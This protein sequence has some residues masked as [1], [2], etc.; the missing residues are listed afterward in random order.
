[1]TD[2]PLTFNRG[3]QCGPE[4]GHAHRCVGPSTH[5]AF[6]EVLVP[7]RRAVSVPGPPRFTGDSLIGSPPTPTER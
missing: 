7:G 6:D 5:R 2:D 1:M 3:I 4:A